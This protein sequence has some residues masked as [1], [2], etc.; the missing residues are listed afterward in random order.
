MLT[1][2]EFLPVYIQTTFW[3]CNPSNPNVCDL[4]WDP[5]EA[6]EVE[7]LGDN[8][9][10]IEA[11]TALIIPFEALPQ[12]TQQFQPGSGGQIRYLLSK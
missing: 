8:G 11:M 9:A 12:Q 5:D 4:I 6:T 10:R 3:D 7:L 1:I 2:K